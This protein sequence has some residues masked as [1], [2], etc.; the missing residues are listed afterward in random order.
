M[1]TCNSSKD[2]DDK[3]NK[4]GAFLTM[5]IESGNEEQKIFCQRVLN[6]YECPVHLEYKITDIYNRYSI[7]LSDSGKKYM[8]QNGGFINSE[9]SKN[10]I[11]EQIYKILSSNRGGK[12]DEPNS[13]VRQKNIE[14]KG[15]KGGNDKEGD[16]KEENKDNK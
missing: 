1:G 7:S 9:H 11:L 14:I 4:R 15:E 13:R 16:K 12:L 8:I 2:S 10:F 6:S 5:N 3:S